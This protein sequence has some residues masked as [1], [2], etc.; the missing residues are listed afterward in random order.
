MCDD[1]FIEL[2]DTLNGKQD[3]TFFVRPVDK[4]VFEY[5]DIY[6]ICDVWLLWMAFSNHLLNLAQVIQREKM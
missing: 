2:E 5:A 4:I 3:D 1:H 6:I